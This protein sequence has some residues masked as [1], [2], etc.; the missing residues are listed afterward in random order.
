MPCSGPRQGDYGAT[1]SAIQVS[2]IEI[3][4]L[5]VAVR[6]ATRKLSCQCAPVKNDAVAYSLTPAQARCRFN[7]TVLAVH[8]SPVENADPGPPMKGTYPPTCLPVARSP[9]QPT[10]QHRDKLD[11]VRS[12][13]PAGST[14]PRQRSSTTL[15]RTLF[16]NRGF[17]KTV[18][19][20]V[21]R[22]SHCSFS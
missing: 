4:Q 20:C 5:W 15:E 19:R 21:W 16:G 3:L 22:D 6:Q 7:L 9:P 18:L 10:H 1:P 13:R 8:L 17:L 12:K 11:R 14:C 2:L